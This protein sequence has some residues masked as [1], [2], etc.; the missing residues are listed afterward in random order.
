MGFNKKY[1]PSLT[2]LQKELEKTPSAIKSYWRADLLIGPSDT[3]S[4]IES[5]R[6]SKNEKIRPTEGDSVKTQ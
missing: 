2:E 6:K 3:I 5:L 1:V 4:Y